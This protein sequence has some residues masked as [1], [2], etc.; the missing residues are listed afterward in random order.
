M[1]IN[2]WGLGQGV[3]SLGLIVNIL[4]I[5]IFIRQGFK[6]SVNVSLFLLTISDLGSLV[7]VFFLNLVTTGTTAWIAMERCLC[8]IT[9]LKVKSLITSRRTVVFVCVLY[10]IST[11][12]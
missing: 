8:I 1:L 6:E 7:F 4:N 10:L 12:S 11:A 9:P 3:T 2:T 5:I